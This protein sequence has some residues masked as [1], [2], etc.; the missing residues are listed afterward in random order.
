MA[1]AKPTHRTSQQHAGDAAE[2]LVAD[3]L[4]GTGWAV[5]ARNVRIGRRELDIVAIDPG[6]PAELVVIEVRWRRDRAYGLPEETADWRKRRHVRSAAFALLD[7]GLPGGPELPALP[8]RFDLVVVE[9]SVQPGDD[10]RI[11]H[12]RHVFGS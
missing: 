6:P 10:P 5:L 9:P 11:R 1:D 4:A 2:A 3:R 12:H 8:L 7:R